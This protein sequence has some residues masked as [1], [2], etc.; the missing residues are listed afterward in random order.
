MFKNFHILEHRTNLLLDQGMFEK[1]SRCLLSMYLKALTALELVAGMGGD[2]T[3]SQKHIILV[4]THMRIHRTWGTR[5]ARIADLRSVVRTLRWQLPCTGIHLTS[6]TTPQQQEHVS[7]AAC[8]CSLLHSCVHAM[9]PLTWPALLRC[10]CALRG[11]LILCGRG[12]RS[13]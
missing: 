4:K 13:A 10:L 9:G 7:V 5:G 8:A 2:H 12:R 1:Y 11:G 6:A 3:H